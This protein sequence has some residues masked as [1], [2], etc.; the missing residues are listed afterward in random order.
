[1]IRFKPNK[2]ITALFVVMLSAITFG[3]EPL[4]Q[5]AKGNFFLSPNLAWHTI[6]ECV[7]ETD[8]V[9]TEHRN[10]S[11][12][13]AVK[14][15]YIP[16]DRLAVGLEINITESGYF[17]FEEAIPIERSSIGLGLFS[18]YYVYKGL[19]SE[20]YLGLFSK[21]VSTVLPE[22]DELSA[23]LKH[24]ISIGYSYFIFKHLAIEPMINFSNKRYRFR[25]AELPDDIVS[26]LS[27][28]IAITLS[29]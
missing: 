27:L 3:Q 4:K 22:D 11:K 23:I 24:R 19:F 20:G 29:L 5:T 10:V 2:T 28:G 21:D 14:I 12:V 6:K 17:N 8:F 16:I 13:L 7:S 25:G 26:P 18:R 1:M 15:G 9:S